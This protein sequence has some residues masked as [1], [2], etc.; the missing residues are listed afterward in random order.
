MQ[1]SAILG[2][3]SA[4]STYDPARGL[5]TFDIRN[6]SDKPAVLA[7]NESP[8]THKRLTILMM[9]GTGKLATARRPVPLLED[10][11]ASQETIAPGASHVC[12]YDVMYW[13]GK[14]AVQVAQL[15]SGQDRT[16][17]VW[18]YEPLKENTYR[19]AIYGG[20][21]RMR[22]MSHKTAARGEP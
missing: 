10:T 5:L 12:W 18:S 15:A 8:R 11:G 16:S 14:V 22:V 2:V 21:Y 19:E 6:A 20:S 13:F 7:I 1:A 17:L 3:L 9:V 4:S